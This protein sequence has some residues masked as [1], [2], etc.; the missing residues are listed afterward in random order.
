MAAAALVLGILS[1]ALP[2]V[3]CFLPVIVHVIAIVLGIVA[4]ILGVKAGKAEPEKAGLAKAGL[5]MG[6][7]GVALAGVTLVLCGIPLMAGGAALTNLANDPDVLNALKNM[8]TQ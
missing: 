5:V 8:G 1:L 6:I 7:I 2:W 4:I 3:L